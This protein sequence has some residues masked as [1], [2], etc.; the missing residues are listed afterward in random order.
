MT[1]VNSEKPCR[2]QGGAGFLVAIESGSPGCKANSVRGKSPLMNPLAEIFMIRMN[3][4]RVSEFI[5]VVPEVNTNWHN[6][7]RTAKAAFAHPVTTVSKLWLGHMK[8]KRI[9]ESTEFTSTGK[10]HGC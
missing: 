9:T 7:L 8:H 1:D 6:M 3:F 4:H 10:P 2:L 5:F